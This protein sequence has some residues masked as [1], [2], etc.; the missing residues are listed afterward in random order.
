[1]AS[2]HSSLPSQHECCEPVG[3]IDLFEGAAE[4]SLVL[5]AVSVLIVIMPRGPVALFSA[6]RGLK[7]IRSPRVRGCQF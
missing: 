3:F 4:T 5:T 1:M 2:F 7:G 6:D